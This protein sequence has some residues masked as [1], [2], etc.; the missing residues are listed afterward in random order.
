MDNTK[1]LKVINLWWY[2]PAVQY[3]P[4]ALNPDNYHTCQLLLWAPRMMW[5][6]NFHCPHCGI[7]ES[8]RSKGLYNR[9]RLVLDVKNQY[10]MAG[11]YMDCRGCSGTFISWDHRM[12]SQLADGV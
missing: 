11:K 4:V 6:V 9:V 2:P 1:S 3:N 10:Y 8:L 12:L 7:K 5:K